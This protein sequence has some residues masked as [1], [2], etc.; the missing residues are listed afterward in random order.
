MQQGEAHLEP[1]VHLHDEPVEE[2]TREGGGARWAHLVLDP[3]RR[4]RHA[5]RPL[6]ARGSGLME[7]KSERL[8]A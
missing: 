2:P 3:C 5:S 7:D 1:P 4:D 8:S 6:A